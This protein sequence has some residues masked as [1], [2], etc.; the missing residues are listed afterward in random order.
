MIINGLLNRG[1]SL[2]VISRL[3]GKWR[4]YLVS[5]SN[6]QVEC[7][8]YVLILHLRPVLLHQCLTAISATVT[9]FL[10]LFKELTGP[11]YTFLLLFHQPAEFL[12]YIRNNV[13]GILDIL[14]QQL[15]RFSSDM[16]QPY[17]DV[18]RLSLGDVAET[19]NTNLTI[20]TELQ[21]AIITYSPDS[22]TNTQS[23]PTPGKP[24]E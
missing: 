7:S 16:W 22:N 15:S 20:S 23:L 14:W 13:L 19:S 8:C 3:R 12:A 18:I 11:T 1:K 21:P 10:K 4:Q 17:C 9:Y 24:Y 5:H 2:F 6:H